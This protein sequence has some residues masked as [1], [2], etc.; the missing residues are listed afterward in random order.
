MNNPYIITLQ[1]KK[2]I[3]RDTML[4]AFTRPANFIYKAGQSADITIPNPPETDSEGNVRTFSF[5]STPYENRLMIA[6]RHRNTAFKRVLKKLPFG[7]ELSMEGPF[8]SF[9][10]PDKSET[11]V[12][13][14]TG[15]IGIT[16]VFSMIKHATY[17]TLPH[18]LF[19]F[20]S[21]KTPHDSP[22]LQEL[23]K[24]TKNNPRLTFVATMTRDRT[25]QGK[26]G[27]ISKEIITEYLPDLTKKMF[28]I[29][30]PSEMTTTLRD[31]L[32][33]TGANEDDIYFEDFPSY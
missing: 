11:P 19:L 1:D 5:V 23:E 8:G 6:T 15:G 20:Y 28:Y 17:E 25:W 24:M 14:L 2:E 9:T 22:F 3:A 4:F 18:K 26:K 7:T 16:P 12:V 27:R 29:S 21:N 30:G 33:E 10:L 31:T 32:L 13:F